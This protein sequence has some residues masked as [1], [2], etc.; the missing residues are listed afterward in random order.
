MRQV[1]G[2]DLSEDMQKLIKNFRNAGKT[3]EYMD[4]DRYD[5]YKGEVLFHTKNFENGE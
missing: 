4:K 5:A 2:E 1:S 3:I